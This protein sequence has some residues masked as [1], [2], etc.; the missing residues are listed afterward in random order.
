MRKK[1][2]WGWIQISRRAALSLNPLHKQPSLVCNS[3]L[4]SL[5]VCAGHG[6]SLWASTV[7]H[8]LPILCL[9]ISPCGSVQR[10]HPWVGTWAPSCHS[11][12]WAKMPSTPPLMPFSSFLPVKAKS[13]WSGAGAGNG[14]GHYMGAEEDGR[15]R[16]PLPWALLG[17]STVLAPPFVNGSLQMNGLICPQTVGMNLSV[18]AREQEGLSTEEYGIN[19]TGTLPVPGEHPECCLSQVGRD[20]PHF[21]SELLEACSACPHLA[22]GRYFFTLDYRR[23]N[24]VNWADVWCQ[25]INVLVWIAARSCDYGN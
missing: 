9:V 19:E 17:I 8:R 2:F 12:P 13:E 4:K 20:W 25:F 14:E 24:C 1:T 23:T 11:W 15:S 7:L 3:K 6:R 5:G 18:G 22:S 16:H 10:I 21:P